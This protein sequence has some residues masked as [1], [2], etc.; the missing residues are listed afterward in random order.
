MNYES[1]NLRSAVGTR[2][3]EYFDGNIYFGTFFERLPEKATELSDPEIEELTD[4]IEHEP[5]VGG[6]FGISLTEHA[7]YRQRMANVIKRLRKG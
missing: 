4:L 1:S 5:A 7:E 3:Q 6:F 2:A